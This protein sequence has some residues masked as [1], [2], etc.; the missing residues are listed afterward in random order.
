LHLFFRYN[1]TAAKKLQNPLSMPNRNF[2][3]T[4]FLVTSL[5]LLAIVAISNCVVAQGDEKKVVPK[6]TTIY[7]YIEYYKDIAICEMERSGIPASITLAQGIHESGCGNSKL[8]TEANNHFGIKCHKGWMGN[9]YYQW[10]DDPAESCF[11]VYDNAELS[12]VDHSEFLITRKH[13][14]FL[15]GYNRTEYEKWA[16]GLKKAGYATD[17]TYPEKLI[18]TIQK[19]K[20]SDYDLA[21]APINL[22]KL[23]SAQIAPL[24]NPEVYVIPPNMARKF[25]YK[26]QSPLF[27]TYKKGF[28][29]QN[30]IT[31][32]IVQENETALEIATRFDIPYRKFLIF[33]DLVDGDRL[34]N[35]Q[36][37][38]LYP[39]K[40][41][42]KGDEQFHR[43]INNETMYEI[44]QFYGLHLNGLLERNL[45]QEGQEP[46]NGELILLNEKV[47]KAPALRPANLKE[48]PISDIGEVPPFPPSEKVIIRTDTAKATLLINVPTYPENIYNS[49]NK[50][51]TAITPSEIEITPKK[52]TQLISPKEE[53]EEKEPIIDN[54]EIELPTAEKF[55]EPIKEALIPE[56][57]PL[58]E[59]PAE[60]PIKITPV[61]NESESFILHTV[62]A[63]ETL[64]GIGKKYGISTQRIQEYNN[65]PSISLKEKQVLKIPKKQ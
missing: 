51:N 6:K 4:G 8:A 62:Q 49:D 13:Y 59:L 35:F 32:A 46:L 9:S 39:K 43:V 61:V 58:V 56:E 33:N 24:R 44:S 3:P 2:R 47:V 60:E 34:I 18:G 36:Y 19:Y 37:C 5:S 57:K 21:M 28:F 42:Y 11:R 65:L 16:K 53:E 27:A 25:R 15:F 20:L 54:I 7:E 30:G 45:I 48:E 1:Q 17:P 14:S 52:D 63:K 50:I 31:Y 10:D 64:F 55:E 41:R 12:Y 26:K 22:A 29:I 38:Y 23:D 40:S